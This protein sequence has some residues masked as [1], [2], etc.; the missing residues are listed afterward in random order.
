MKN[1]NSA[2]R[3]LKVLNRG[4]EVVEYINRNPG[5]TLTGLSDAL[6]LPKSTLHIYLKTLER[7]GYIV[8]TGAGYEIGFKFF[9]LG[10]MRRK[11]F[12]LYEVAKESM[13]ELSNEIDD[14]FNVALGIEEN[15]KRVLLF[16]TAGQKSPY[17]DVPIGHT[18]HLHWTSQ[19]KALLSEFDDDRI[20]TIV[21]GH[22]LP[23][24]TDNTITSRE[25]LFEELETIRE[26]GYSLEDEE[27]VEGIRSIALPVEGKTGDPYGAISI[28]GPK[29]RI[30]DETIE[31]LVDALRNTT[32]IVEIE[33][34]NY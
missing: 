34:K 25:S 12:R 28:T 17:D 18:T 20:G 2:D 10:G 29:S 8:D 11:R 33:Y 30:T 14:I 5:V 15:G 21:D 24:S 4:F 9:T 31:S 1:Q 16:K 3:E 13:I 19:G 32:N 7:A 26:R 27:R 23:S 6:D 22:G